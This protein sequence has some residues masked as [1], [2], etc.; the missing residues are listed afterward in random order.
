[1]KVLK[2]LDVSSYLVPFD[3]ECILCRPY[4]YNISTLKN[5]FLE[6]SRHKVSKQ[7]L[8]NKKK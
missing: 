6:N 1:M 3:F 5:I 8:L 7:C 4:F 2:E